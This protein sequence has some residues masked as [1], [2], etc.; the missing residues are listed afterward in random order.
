MEH[1]DEQLKLIFADLIRDKLNL[2]RSIAIK[3][4]NSSADADDVVQSSLIK[5]WQ[6]RKS[7]TSDSL[8]LSA[9]IARIVVTESYDLLRKKMRESHKIESYSADSKIGTET[10]DEVFQQ[11]DYAIQQLPEL[12]RTTI[13]IAVLGDIDTDEAARILECSTNTLYQRIFKAKALLKGIMETQK[14]GY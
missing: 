11:L 6:R 5:A 10:N 9:W 3:I 7:F 2:Y 13:N 1:D 14:N 4:V 8:A 12:Y